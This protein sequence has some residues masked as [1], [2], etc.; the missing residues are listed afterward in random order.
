[1]EGG[2]LSQRML[3]LELLLLIVINLKL[4]RVCRGGKLLL[5]VLLL[6]EHKLFHGYLP[7]FF[8][9]FV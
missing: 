1:V 7:R 9:D 6:S 2:E 5:G 4:P 3:V 8:E